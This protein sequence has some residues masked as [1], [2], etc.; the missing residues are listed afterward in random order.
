MLEVWAVQ[1][2]IWPSLVAM[3]CVITVY[4]TWALDSSPI[5]LC[6]LKPGK[7]IN[8]RLI[9]IPIA[10]VYPAFMPNSLQRL[11]SG[12][13]GCH[14]KWGN[15]PW[16]NRP[17]SFKDP[18]YISSPVIC[19]CYICMQNWDWL[20]AINILVMSEFIILVLL[21]QQFAVKR[22]FVNVWCLVKRC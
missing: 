14:R 22:D 4:Q 1:P 7:A 11:E 9:F 15:L 6:K 20:F 12:I 10:W 17:H 8:L 2:Y 21:C 18:F 3:I 13:P 16:N 19:K 5:G